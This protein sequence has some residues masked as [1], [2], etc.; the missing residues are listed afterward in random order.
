MHFQKLVWFVL[1][2]ALLGAALPREY[3][4]VQAKPQDMSDDELVV[5]ERGLHL[6]S[7]PGYVKRVI[8]AIP[9]PVRRKSGLEHGKYHLTT[10]LVQ[11]PLREHG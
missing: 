9:E 6:A 3:Q 10:F 4:Y 11:W 2:A 1:S 5:E 7:S 8:P